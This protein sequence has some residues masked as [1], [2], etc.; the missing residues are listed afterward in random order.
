MVRAIYI[1]I[2]PRLTAAAG[3]SV[4]AHLEDLVARGIVATDGD[5]VIGG[6]Y[7]LAALSLPLPVLYGERSPRL[8]GRWGGGDTA[9]YI[10]PVFGK[11][12]P[13][14]TPPPPQRGAGVYK[15]HSLL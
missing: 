9:P 13:T 15:P 7:R 14:P 4:L 12:G 2:D 8:R 6:T 10:N 11:K 1:G 3:Y 5:P